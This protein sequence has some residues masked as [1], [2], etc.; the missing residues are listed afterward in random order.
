MKI[1][2]RLLK[3]EQRAK[4]TLRCDWCR[5]ALYENSPSKLQKY[6][7]D[8]TLQISVTCS[9]CGADFGVDVSNLNEHEREATLLHYKHERGALFRDERVFASYQWLWHR[10]WLKLWISGELDKEKAEARKKAKENNRRQQLSQKKK[11]DRYTQDRVELKQ[12]ALRF[13][14]RMQ[15]K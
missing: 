4:R 1:D 2:N 6:A 13:A 10:R 14:Q 15:K 3:L 8:P 5:Y 11:E 7:S 9:Y 12:R